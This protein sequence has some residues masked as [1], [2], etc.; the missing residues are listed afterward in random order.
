MYL[1]L[2]FSY[3]MDVTEYFQD[4]LYMDVTEYFQVFS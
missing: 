3:K 2:N 1:F 4:F